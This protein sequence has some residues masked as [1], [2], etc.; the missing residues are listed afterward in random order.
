MPY[1]N[2]IIINEKYINYNNCVTQMNALLLSLMEVRECK[3]KIRQYNTCSYNHFGCGFEEM[4]NNFK[5]I[6]LYFHY[7]YK[8]TTVALS[9]L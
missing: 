9:N 3:N 6:I 1:N 5:N 4:K 7:N 8:V 2:A